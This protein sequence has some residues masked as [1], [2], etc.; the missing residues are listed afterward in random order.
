MEIKQEEIN[1]IIKRLRLFVGFR[2]IWAISL[3]YCAWLRVFLF[4]EFHIFL[5][6]VRFFP[7]YHH[8]LALSQSHAHIHTFLL[9]QEESS[10]LCFN[11]SLS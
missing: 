3:Q 5:P 9:S 4:L 10:H 7:N 6:T 2:G 8:D 1:Y 11:A